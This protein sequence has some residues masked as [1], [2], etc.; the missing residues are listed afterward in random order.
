[1]RRGSV[2]DGI[3]ARRKGFMPIGITG[4]QDSAS[5]AD[6]SNHCW[7]AQRKDD[8]HADS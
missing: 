2:V 4:K 7:A 1:M 3:S 5:Y 8:R 6:Q